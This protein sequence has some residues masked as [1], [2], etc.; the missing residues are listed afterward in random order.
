MKVKEKLGDERGRP[1]KFAPGD[2]VRWGLRMPEDLLMELRISARVAGHS[3]N[4]EMLSR[5]MASLNYK[6]KK[7]TLDSQ[8]GKRLVTLARYFSEFIESKVVNLEEEI[9]GSESDKI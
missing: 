2:E 8:E 1:R 3:I 9:P 5:L 4:D 6:P 7:E